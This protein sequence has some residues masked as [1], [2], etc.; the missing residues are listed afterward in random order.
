MATAALAHDLAL[1]AS[2]APSRR[3]ALSLAGTDPLRLDLPPLPGLRA[4]PESLRAMSALYLAARLEEMGLVAAANALVRDRALLRVPTM[5]AARLEDLARRQ[6]EF[7]PD[8]QRAA[9][10]ARLF[11]AHFEAR[12]AS[13]CSALTA[14]G[15]VPPGPVPGTAEAVWLAGRDLSE[16]AGAVTSGAAILAVPRVNEQLRRC[17]EVL[18]DPGVGALLTARGPWE[19][20]RALLGQGAPDLRRLLDCGRGGQRV[21]LWL[22]TIAGAP[23]TRPGAATPIGAD[24]VAAAAMWLTACG[25]APGARTAATAPA[26][27][28][29]GEGSN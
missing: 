4:S 27:R 5:T 24:I 16:F 1:A 23:P 3:A 22:G 8:A 9:L 17:L 2:A 25:L 21:L 14:C 13:L 10:F 12:L 26:L 7:L 28:S 11:G 20:L 15:P 18:S 19:V 29:L 6:R